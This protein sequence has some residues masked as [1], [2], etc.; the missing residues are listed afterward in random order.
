MKHQEIEDTIDLLVRRSK[1]FSSTD[2]EEAYTA[3]EDCISIL[4]KLSELILE[5][6]VHLGNALEAQEPS[7]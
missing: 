3:T 4:S 7:L 1:A 5:Y 2:T 6:Q